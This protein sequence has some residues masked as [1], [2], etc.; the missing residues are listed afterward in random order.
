MQCIMDVSSDEDHSSSFVSF[1]NEFIVN[2]FLDSSSKT[3]CSKVELHI[4]NPLQVAS[5]R[6]VKSS[7]FKFDMSLQN[8]VSH[9]ES[10]RHTL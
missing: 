2:W 5:S 3:F 9:M 7:L 8:M 1:V 4:L 10:H 6:V